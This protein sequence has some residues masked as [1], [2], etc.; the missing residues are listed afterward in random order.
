[1][2]HVSFRKTLFIFRRDL[3]L[4]DN[5]GLN[6]ALE[7]SKKV[8]PCFIFNPEQI[9]HNPYRS[10]ACLQF[11]IESLEDLENKLREKGGKLY[12]FYGNPIEVIDT[13]IKKLDVEA[14]M[15]NRDYTP[16]SKDRDQK[17]ESL[18]RNHQIPFFTFDDA[19]LHAPEDT[20]KK[21]GTPFKIFTPFYRQAL[22]CEVQ[23]PTTSSHNRYF[24]ELVDF[25]LSPTIYQTILPKRSSK[26]PVKGGRD[27]GKLIL[28]SIKNFSKYDF[29]RDFPA[30]HKTSLLS[31]Y[32]KFTVFSPREVYT[33]ILG[34][35]SKDHALI[36]SLYWRDFFTSIA[37]FFPHVFKGAFHAKYDQLEW[38]NDHEAFQKW[39]MGKTGFPVID[40]GMRQLN[41]T[42]FMHNRVRMIVA[43]F[44]TKDLHLN[45]Q[46]GEKYFAQ[47]L[48]DY[49]PAVNNG[50][51][52]W[53]ASTGCDAQP[54]FRIFNPWNQQKKFDP[55]CG[56]IKEWIPELR[57]LTPPVIHNWHNAETAADYPSPM[58]DHALE[59]KKAL[60]LYKRI[61]LSKKSSP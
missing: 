17:I 10:D 26:L 28:Q 57:H 61:L 34:H 59:A 41:Q 16:F 5:I 60:A 35:F 3:R 52:Q 53:A 29:E 37:F 32:L 46:W 54:Y 45:W 47:K 44:L 23:R 38:N 40:A 20:L 11:M 18:C 9:D 13:C 1:M 4:E 55:E 7:N 30:F 12:L 15:V 48:I 50:N 43:S 42:G 25:S 2:T 6:Y 56:Y 21:D 22:K 49:D 39:Q 36:R 19:L 27:A 33:Y 51:W 31:A 14:V 58:V 8:I 24:S